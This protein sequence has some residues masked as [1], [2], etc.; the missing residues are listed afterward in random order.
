MS[1]R[2]LG[3][4]GKWLLTAEGGRPLAQAMQA[5]AIAACG[6]LG[7]PTGELKRHLEPFK[8]RQMIDCVVADVATQRAADGRPHA[9][10]YLDGP[11]RAE[12]ALSRDHLAAIRDSGMGL[13]RIEKV[14]TGLGF[15]L[16]DMLFRGPSMPIVAQDTSRRAVAGNVLC[17]RLLRSQGVTFAAG[18]HYVLPGYA[19]EN[20]RRELATVFRTVRAKCPPDRQ[21]DDANILRDFTFMFSNA[22]LACELRADR[23]QGEAWRQSA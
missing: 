2:P 8:M 11:G 7:I 5:H 19:G 14:H 13:Y 18:G 9:D 16:Q 23:A 15:I 20:L 3:S 12:P 22:W 17:A 1:A 10:H 6:T 21:P 4:L